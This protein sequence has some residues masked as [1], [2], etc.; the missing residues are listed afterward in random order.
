MNCV[1]RDSLRAIV[2][3]CLSMILLL[4]LRLLLLLLFRDGLLGR[5]RDIDGNSGL[6]AC[7]CALR[8]LQRE[9]QVADAGLLRLQL[10]GEPCVLL[11]E[12]AN[13]V[14]GIA[15]ARMR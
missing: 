4:L 8:R 11:L 7:C 12:L 3:H 1:A 13:L 6:L 10:L 15:P 14:G 5:G 9:L 2:L